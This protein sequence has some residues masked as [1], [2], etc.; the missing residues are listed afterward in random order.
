MDGGFGTKD[1]LQF[2]QQPSLMG[3]A[4]CTKEPPQG[5]PPGP[6]LPGDL[7]TVERGCSGWLS[8]LARQ[9]VPSPQHVETARP[10]ESNNLLQPR[11]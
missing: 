4:V 5:Q 6:T 8:P 1:S 11:K 3:T 7:R 10:A 2:K 9:A